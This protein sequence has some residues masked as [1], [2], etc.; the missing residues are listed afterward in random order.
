MITSTLNVGSWTGFL[1]RGLA[2][3][4]LEAT[5]LAAGGMTVKQ[6]GRAMNIE[7]KT[8]EKRLEAAR[9]KMGCRTIR[10]L[11]VASITQ[12]L[13]AFSTPAQTP[14]GHEDHDLEKGVFL[15]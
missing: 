3:R 4:E 13:I 11:V 7:P 2:E 6:I 15:A 5:L 9:F 1:G 14:Q 8:A 12:G 10:D